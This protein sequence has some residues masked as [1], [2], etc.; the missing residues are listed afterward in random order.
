MQFSKYIHGDN[1]YTHLYMDSLCWKSHFT[2]FF[3]HEHIMSTCVINVY[4]MVSF[5]KKHFSLV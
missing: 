4:T 2:N 5:F 3:L 1:I